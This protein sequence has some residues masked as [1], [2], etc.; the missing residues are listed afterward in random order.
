[1]TI[2]QAYENITAA[3]RGLCVLESIPSLVEEATEEKV[4]VRA[5]LIRDGA[6]QRE[7]TEARE[8][9]AN[10]E[11][12]ANGVIDELNI[13]VNHGNAFDNVRESVATYVVNHS[14]EELAYRKL[15]STLDRSSY[16]WREWA[17]NLLKVYGLATSDGN[18]AV[19]A[20]ICELIG[21]LNDRAENR[22]HTI[23]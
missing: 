7:L 20:R 19:R 2:K 8:E 6:T 21:E 14:N 10:W 11:L 15:V 13:P 1:M 9:L 16:D 23:D 18:D 5:T 3:L 17:T 12:W 22:D 4:H